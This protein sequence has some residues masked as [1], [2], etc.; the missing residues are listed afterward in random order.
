MTSAVEVAAEIAEAVRVFSRHRYSAIVIWNPSAAVDG[1]VVLDAV[2]SRQL[3]IAIFAPEP[4]S[5]LSTGVSVIRDT[6]IERAGVPIAWPYVVDRASELAAGFAFLVDDSTGEIRRIDREGVIR[7][8]DAT[9]IGSE[10]HRHALESRS[11]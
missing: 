7:T 11:G 9:A 5:A 3:L 8:V 1:G 2:V 10:L 6:R 4:K